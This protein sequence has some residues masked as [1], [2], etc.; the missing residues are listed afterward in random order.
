MTTRRSP[1]ARGNF[2]RLFVCGLVLYV[3]GAWTTPGTYAQQIVIPRIDQMPNQP[4]PYLMRDW[5]QVAQGY[6]ALV[7]DLDRTGQYLPLIW[8]VLNTVNYPE[9]ESFGLATV[10]GT[11][12]IGSSEAINVLPALVGATLVGVDKRN[13]NGENWV[14]MAE[15]YFNRRPEENVYLNLPVTQSGDDWWYETMPNV[16][17]YQLYDLYPG[18]GDFAYQF[19][20]VADQWLRAVEAMGGSTTPWAVPSMNYRAWSLATMT[21]LRSGVPEPEAAGAIAWLLYHAYVE[22]GEERYRI[23]AEWAMDFLNARTSNPAYELQLAY[24][25]YAAARM[26][27]E[28]GTTYDVE[29]M[30]NWSFDVGPLRSWGA[31]VGTWGGYDVSGLIGEVSS[32][33]YAFL[34]NG[35]QQASALVPMTRY[36]DRFSRAIGKWVLNMANASRLF[37]PTYLPPENQDSETWSLQYDPDAYIGHEALRREQF[38]RSPYATGDAVSGGWGFT[39]LA[40]YGSSHVGIL[41]G[42]VD[43]TDVPMILRLDLLKTDSFH[44]AAYPTYLY[45]NPYDDDQTVTVDAGPGLYDLYDAVANRFLATGVSGLTPLVL[46]A[47]AAVQMVVT[48]AGG[49]ITHD[50]DRMLVD[51]VVVD[52]RSGQGPANHPPRIRS[53]TGAPQVV[54]TGEATMLYCTAEDRDDDSLT[55]NW[56]AS[57]GTFTGSGSVVTWTAPTTTGTYPITCTVDDGQGESTESTTTVAVIDNHAPVIDSVTAVPDIL[58]A[59]ATTTLTCT[60]YDPDGD[61]LTYAWEASQGSLDG[62]GPSVTWTA[63][64]ENGYFT[65]S[66]TVR[67]LAGAEISQTTGVVVGHLVGHYPFDGDARDGSGFGNHGNVGGAT[68]T[69][70]LLGG[71]GNAYAFDGV[72]DYIRIPVH[73][74]LNFEDAVSLNFWMKADASLDREAF[75]I[76]HGSWQ[77]RWKVSITPEQRL[78]WTAKTEA[79]VFDLD[80]GILTPEALYNVTVT[81]GEGTARIYLNGLLEAERSWSGAM[82]QTSFDLT[83]GQI[84]PGDNQWNFAGHLDDVRIYNT[85][86]SE[87]DIRVLAGLGTAVEDPGSPEDLPPATTLYANY[88]NPF[89]D[90]TVLR[91]DL[92]RA[93]P[94]DILVFNLLGQKVRTL[95]SGTELPGRKHITWDGRDDNGNRVA[96]G[97]YLVQLRLS[98]QRLHRKL[99]RL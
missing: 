52:Y 29:K 59:R 35:Y 65:I 33:D 91:Y 32:N 46:P 25:V 16:F 86:L 40:L 42:I 69:D 97:I 18:T 20:S 89:R 37:Y 1:C 2:A 47:D 28:L 44:D 81:Y 38:G 41:G 64:A 72:D 31:I 53:L 83:I 98:N 30:V 48:P 27:A 39:N 60:A 50:L 70:D 68:L 63:P 11:P 23:G 34:M 73:P 6:D 95:Y 57:T 14:L 74:S 76:S 26:N 51:G 56:S 15:E 99:L 82:L 94:V 84:L 85:V 24:G 19:Q 22:T 66:C 21:P 92:N 5:K 49:M 12:R 71:T 93:G 61:A 10:V 75:V 62:D 43:T 4:A 9:H 87:T 36:D 8:R 67:D 78:R 7:F 13:Q 58:D 80:S 90:Y 79:G 54:S 55:Y 45:F 17:F 96:S 88:P 3:L 77:N